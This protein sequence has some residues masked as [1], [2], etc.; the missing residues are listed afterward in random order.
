MRGQYNW[1][2]ANDRRPLGQTHPKLQQKR[3]DLTDRAGTITH[4]GLAH[5][6]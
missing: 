1:Q 3:M 6:V 2:P 4:Q 5:P